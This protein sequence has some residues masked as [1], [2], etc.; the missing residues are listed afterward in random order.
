[1]ISA[2]RQIADLVDLALPINKSKT[3][4]DKILRNRT[5][6]S[7]YFG[8]DGLGTKSMDE[9]GKQFGLTKEMVRQIINKFKS[10]IAENKGIIKSDAIERAIAV[11]SQNCSNSAENVTSALYKQ[12]LIPE[13]YL[14][15]GIISAAELLNLTPLG[16]VLT[17]VNG[18]PF[19]FRT[20][21]D[22]L[23]K[24]TLSH[25]IK[26]ISHDG[27][28]NK[29]ALVKI[30]KGSVPF[31]S[32]N[33]FVEQLIESMP[34]FRWI[35]KDAGTFYFGLHGRN[36]LVSRLCKVFNQY[37]S[38]MFD[39]LLEAIE[40]S[41]KKDENNEIHIPSQ[42]LIKDVINDFDDV[43]FTDPEQTKINC[44]KFSSN[45]ALRIFEYE[46][47]KM[48]SD[49]KDQVLREKVIEDALVKTV[50]D[51]YNYSM[52]LNYSPLI[53]RVSRGIYGI[54]GKVKKAK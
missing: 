30:I 26:R 34:N 50:P 9:A 39:D 16:F 32:Q 22:D 13:H 38:V 54:T 24:K 40:R 23:G 41:W 48:I 44:S 14:I 15:D 12:G 25:A 49:S 33:T 19:V 53:K 21:E 31:S 1:M 28:C 7:A 37:D 27:Y 3:K 29:A 8:F 20:S 6:V 47:F 52:S 36:R 11:I 45:V 42:E 10:N 35:N 4:K 17:K 43:K 5:I 2:Q 18:I 51:K 46:I